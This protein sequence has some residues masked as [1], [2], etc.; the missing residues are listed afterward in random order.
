MENAYGQVPESAKRR[1]T[2]IFEA[3]QSY[4]NGLLDKWVAWSMRPLAIVEVSGLLEFIKF[5]TEVLGG[6][7]M[8][9]AGATQTREF[10]LRI[11]AEIRA[12][13]KTHIQ[14]TCHYCCITTDIWASR[15]AQSYMALT[16]HYVDEGFVMPSW[17]LEVEPFP[18]MHTDVAIAHGL[19]DMMER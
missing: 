5:I 19:K 6:I 15:R 18:G 16:L 1:L 12:F 4:A 13:F 17:A 8:E 11:A 10:I 3:Q 9:V 2:A 7:I 14:I